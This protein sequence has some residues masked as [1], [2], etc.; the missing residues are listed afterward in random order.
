MES[1]FPDIELYQD[2][3][4]LNNGKINIVSI[5]HLEKIKGLEQ[6]LY[7]AAERE[8]IPCS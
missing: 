3:S 1:T 4:R 6:L 5:A 2:N 8:E 7:L